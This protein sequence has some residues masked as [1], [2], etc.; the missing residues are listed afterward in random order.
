MELGLLM[1]MW[2]IVLLVEKLV[3][4]GQLRLLLALFLLQSH[5]LLEHGRV[6]SFLVLISALRRIVVLPVPMEWV[7]SS[8]R[9]LQP[10][11]F[12]A[13]VGA[14]GRLHP[15]WQSRPV[16]LLHARLV[17]VRQRRLLV[18]EHLVQV[19]AS[20]AAFEMIPDLL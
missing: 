16:R 1:L 4:C 20:M 10:Q 18:L 13:T 5:L 11:N 6:L 15:R 14:D 12:I 8:V 17:D 2:L 9:T 19:V 7:S 3:G